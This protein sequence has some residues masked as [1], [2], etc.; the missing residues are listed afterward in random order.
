MQELDRFVRKGVAHLENAKKSLTVVTSELFAGLV[1]PAHCDPVFN[2]K[3]AEA[4]KAIDALV[5][6]MDE[7]INFYKRGGK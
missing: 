2:E 3:C 7:G 1:Y 4:R 6:L 5:L